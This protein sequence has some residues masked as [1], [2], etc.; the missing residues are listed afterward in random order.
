MAVG[1]TNAMSGPFSTN[2]AT[3][4]FPFTFT[5]LSADDVKLISRDGDGL[6]T[7]VSPALYSVTLGAISGGTVTFD[8]APA[9]GATLFILLDPGMEQE[10]EF[11][12]GGRYLARAH[13]NVADRAVLRDQAL[14]RDVGRALKFPIGETVTGPAFT[15]NQLNAMVAAGFVAGLAQLAENVGFV[16]SGTGALAETLDDTARRVVYAAQW[17]VAADGTT[18]DTAK[19]QALLDAHPGKDIV[20]DGA[21]K[22]STITVSGDNTR[23]IFRNGAGFVY[24]VAT[25]KPVNVTGDNVTLEGLN[26]TGPAIFDGTNTQPLYGMVWVTGDN[27][28]IIGGKL[29]NVPKVGIA[30]TECEGGRVLGTTIE[31]NYP[32][33]SFTGTQTGHFGILIDCAAGGR[34]GNFIIQGCDI[35]TCVQGVMVANYGPTARQHGIIISG[36]NFADIWNHGVYS[37]GLTYGDEVV[38]NTFVRAGVAVAL[39]GSYHVVSSNTIT[40]GGGSGTLA[41]ETGISLRDPIGCV[42]IGNTLQGEVGTGQIVI[43]LTTSLGTVAKGN[44]VQGNTMDITGSGSAT[45]IAIGGTNGTDLTDNI[46]QGNVCKGTGRTEIGL[47]VVNGAASC[48]AHGTVIDNNTT[49]AKSASHGVQIVNLVGAAVSG[50]RHRIEFDLGSALQLAGVQFADCSNC[51]VH[52]NTTTVTAAWGANLQYIGIWETGTS[53]GNR[54]WNNPLRA[55]PTKIVYGIP[56]LTVDGSGILVRDIG[57]GAPNLSAGVGSTWGRSDGGAGTALYVKESGSGATGWV[58]K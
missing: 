49:V 38:G 6:E 48:P 45:M 44:I 56:Y 53:S 3:T 5:A 17:G 52:D 16:Q 11:E 33:G 29:T 32:S 57:T 20:F 54:A 9:S 43:N 1:T 14:K 2:G 12:E 47:I 18:D 26:L 31:G 55:D 22:I 58:G 15:F 34:E 50:N 51:D 39:S 24:T 21:S 8:A 27:C 25:A 46:I 37:A 41:D 28:K 23:L 40:T 30:F 19:V 36:N 10:T 13:N 7:T 42:V 4:A 35:S